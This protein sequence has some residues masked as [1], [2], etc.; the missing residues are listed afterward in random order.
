MP[1]DY[2]PLIESFGKIG[3]KAI[4]CSQILETASIF[5]LHE[6]LVLLASCSLNI[7]RIPS[8]I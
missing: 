7:Y 2:A 8:L 5:N 1:A 6:N 4:S 3:L